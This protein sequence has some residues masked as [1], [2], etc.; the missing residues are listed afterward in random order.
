MNALKL[1]LLALVALINVLPLIGLLSAER[2][3]GLYG[4]PPLEPN[5]ALLMRHRA[6]LFGLVGALILSAVFLPALRPVAYVV[7]LI[8]MAGF[9][10]LARGAAINEAL[11]HV[12]LA[13]WIGLGLLAV[14]L[15]L[16]LLQRLQR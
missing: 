8:S 6:L 12:V 13:D 5:L 14:V 1:V 2:V 3:Q 15:L 4:L 11:Q 10:I 16:E 7:A 9:I